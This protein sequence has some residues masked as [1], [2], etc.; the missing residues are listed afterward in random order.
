MKQLILIWLIITLIIYILSLMAWL[1]MALMSLM[2]IDNGMTFSA[3]FFVAI[4]WAY[5][6]L[7]ILFEYL[8]WYFFVKLQYL[9]AFIFGT[10]PMIV[11]ILIW[12]RIR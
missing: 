2:A 12:V 6:W 9:Q 4:I 8:S 5:P 3:V 11:I 7:L 1:S 10:I